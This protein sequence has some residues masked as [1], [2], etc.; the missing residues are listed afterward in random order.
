MVVNGRA[1]T[2]VGVA[3][4]GFSGEMPGQTPELFVPI[5]MKKEMTADW[6]GLKDRKD[7]WV[8][9]FGRLKPGETLEQAQT[10]INVT[11]QPQLQQDIALLTNTTEDSLKK[12]RAKKIELK[13]GDYGRGSLREQG[14]TAPAAAARDDA[15]R[16]P[17]RLRQRRQPAAHARA[18]ADARN[19]RPP[20]AGRVTPSAH[21]P[22]AARSGHRRRHRRGGGARGRLL[23]AA[24]DPR[25]RCRRARSAPAC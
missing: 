9:L 15:A 7:Y 10:A 16:A 13:A 2:I 14:K 20:R 6:D 23:D 25:R 8:T 17:H 18:G 12:W 5:T 24:R 11:Y 22:A 1:M 3:Q 4:R 21:R 19:R